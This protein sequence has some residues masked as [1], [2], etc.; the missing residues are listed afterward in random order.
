[1][2]ATALVAPL[3]GFAAPAPAPPSTGRWI[4]DW[5][6]HICTLIRQ[7]GGAEAL[8]LSRAPGARTMQLRWVNKDWNA[9]SRVRKAELFLE[10]GHVRI[11]EFEAVPLAG[12]KGVGSEGINYHVLDQ[13]EAARSIR[14]LDGGKPVGEIGLPGADQAVRALRECNDSALRDYGLDPARMASL[15]EL[16]KWRESSQSLISSLDYP[17]EAIRLG[18]SGISVVRLDIDIKGKVERCAIVKSSNN[19]DLDN[20]T[21]RGLSR[22][23]FNPAIGPDGNP[24]AASIINRIVWKSD[25]QVELDEG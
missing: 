19:S 16:P 14:L 22:A 20:T 6:N 12:H 13:L 15:R 2:A 1:M 23:H 24:V 8:A 21:C 7:T 17:G 9:R 10:P 18:I 11:E 5:G 25:D 4:S 3:C